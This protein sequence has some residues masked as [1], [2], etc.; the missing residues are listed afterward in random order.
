MCSHTHIRVPWN[1]CTLTATRI[2]PGSLGQSPHTPSRP[3]IYSGAQPVPDHPQSRYKDPRDARTVNATLTRASFLPSLPGLVQEWNKSP[4]SPPPLL[5]LSSPLPPGVQPLCPP[6]AEPE[7]ES[8][9]SGK[10]TGA[11]TARGAAAGQTAVVTMRAAA[12]EHP[13]EAMAR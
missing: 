8:R 2:H 11:R 3:C 1:T 6:A 5:P 4:T 7:L 9:Q 10:D 12:A 13:G